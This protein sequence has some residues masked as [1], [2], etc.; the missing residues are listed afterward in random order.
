MTGETRDKPMAQGKS[1]M[2]KLWG[3]I[4]WDNERLAQLRRVQTKLILTLI[5]ETLEVC[6]PWG[7]NHVHHVGKVNQIRVSDLLK[8][9]RK[10]RD[11]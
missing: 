2:H 6:R 8:G 1:N 11:S 4:H 3:R 5:V 7:C 10:D 9:S